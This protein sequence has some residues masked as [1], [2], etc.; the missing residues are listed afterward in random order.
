M[1]TMGDVEEDFDELQEESLY[2]APNV[3]VTQETMFDVPI[4]VPE[5]L[6]EEEEI[7]EETAMEQP[8]CVP[9]TCF[10]AL[11]VRK[12][13]ER[14]TLE[15]LNTKVDGPGKVVEQKME[16]EE[17]KMKFEELKLKYEEANMCNVM[18]VRVVLPLIVVMLALLMLGLSQL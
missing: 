2:D 12:I 10:P 14:I 5:S 18:Y 17:Q 16:F 15:K 9:E 4:N 13:S 11:R 1:S 8:T 7:V 3:D 6:P